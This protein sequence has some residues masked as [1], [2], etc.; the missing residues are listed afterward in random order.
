MRRP[1]P[2]TNACSEPPACSG[3]GGRARTLRQPKKD[4]ASRGS[5]G[6]VQAKRQRFAPMRPPRNL[7]KSVGQLSPKTRRRIC[8]EPAEVNHKHRTNRA[9][10]WD[11]AWN[12][13]QQRAITALKGSRSTTNRNAHRLHS[14]RGARRTAGRRGRRGRPRPRHRPR[15]GD[16]R[17]GTG[18]AVD[19][20]VRRLLVHEAAGFAES[21]VSSS[22]SH[23]PSPKSPLGF[24]ARV[25]PA[26]GGDA[27]SSADAL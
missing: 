15:P 25:S 11:T 16:R 6:S 8:K 7:R 4:R 13:S 18:L 23:D 12:W 2:P 10:V 26:W 9:E 24:T 3:K 22:V 17:G 5:R 27:M 19:L 21:G 14:Q 1:T 20:R